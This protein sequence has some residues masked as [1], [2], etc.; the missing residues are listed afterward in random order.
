MSQSDKGVP[1]GLGNTAFS[2][3]VAMQRPLSLTPFDSS[4]FRGAMELYE[5]KDPYKPEF[6]EFF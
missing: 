4:P 3:I 2:N 5:F 1:E 6:V